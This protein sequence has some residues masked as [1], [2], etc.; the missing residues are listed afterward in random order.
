M[1]S[2]SLQV[3]R[4]TSLIGYFGLFVFL[5]LWLTW[6]S[7]SDK[8]PVALTL[9]VLVTPLLFPLRGILYGR[10]YTHAWASF[11]ALFYFTLAIGVVVSEPSERL[12]GIIWLIL[13]ILMY[14]GCMFYARIK[15][16]A[17]KA[18]AAATNSEHHSA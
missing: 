18:A 2:N 16:K 3:A 10:A 14:G 9:I 6:L 15:G 7:P 5:L 13:S 4:I 11:L 17:E 1:Q 12:Y 8:F